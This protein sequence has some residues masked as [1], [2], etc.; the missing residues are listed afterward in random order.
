[1][2]LGSFALF[3]WRRQSCSSDEGSSCRRDHGDILVMD[4]PMPGRVSS[5]NE[6]WSGTGS[7]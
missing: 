2:S 5:S 1:M 7:D 3:R 4:G 6:L